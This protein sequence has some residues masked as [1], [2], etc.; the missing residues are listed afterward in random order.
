MCWF[1]SLLTFDY[2]SAK[3]NIFLLEIKGIHS[4]FIASCMIISTAALLKILKLWKYHKGFSFRGKLGM[5]QISSGA[6]CGDGESHAALP[7]TQA[8][9]RSLVPGDGESHAALPGAMGSVTV[10]WLR[11]DTPCHPR[12]WRVS[13]SVDPS[14]EKC[15]SVSPQVAGSLMQCWLG[16]QW[17]T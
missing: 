4:C 12:R 5:G 6:A 10:R 3:C 7:E 16:R 9:L 8:V 11:C 2:R 13:C 14:D 15:Y 17:V 1:R